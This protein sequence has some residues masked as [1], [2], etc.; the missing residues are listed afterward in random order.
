[1]STISSVVSLRALKEGCF[2]AN[3]RYAAWYLRV[4]VRVEGQGRAVSVQGSSVQGAF[5]CGDAATQRPS[6]AASAWGNCCWGSSW[7][8]MGVSPA[9]SAYACGLLHCAPQEALSASALPSPCAATALIL[10]LP[11]CVHAFMYAAA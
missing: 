9:A 4:G 6:R 8:A 5:H 1:M 2:L 3:S 11:L 10:Q 7:V